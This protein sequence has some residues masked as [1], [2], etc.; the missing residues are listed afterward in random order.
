MKIKLGRA[1][2]GLLHRMV[3]QPETIAVPKNP[4]QPHPPYEAPDRSGAKMLA[5]LI[6]VVRT[7]I[8]KETGSNSWEIP[9]SWEGS[10]KQTFV[11]KL[12]EIVVHYQALGM[13]STFVQQYWNIR[14]QLEGKTVVDD[15]LSD[16]LDDVV[17]DELK[18]EAE[19][20][21]PNSV[22]PKA[23]KKPE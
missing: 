16:V 15:D 13:S 6:K 22:E 19:L 4:T 23:D 20:T 9:E 5:K 14:D 10:I 12:S 8:M 21:P 18:R 3:C 11:D 1:E 2:I 7:K 17:E